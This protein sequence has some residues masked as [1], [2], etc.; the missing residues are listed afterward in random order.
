MQWR[1]RGF[2][3]S[4]GIFQAVAFFSASTSKLCLK[5]CRSKPT[6]ATAKV[7]F[8]GALDESPH[9]DQLLNSHAMK[10]VMN[11]ETAEFLKSDNDAVNVGPK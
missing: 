8:C 1:Y 7:Y 6:V 3:T 2:R 11:F 9:E 4:K 5:Y 10:T